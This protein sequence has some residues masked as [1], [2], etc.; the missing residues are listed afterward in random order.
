[1]NGKH[2]KIPIDNYLL[3]DLSEVDRLGDGFSICWND[4]GYSWKIASTYAKVI[5]NKLDT[6]KYL[7]YQPISNDDN[8]ISEEYKRINC[9]VFLIR[10]DRQPWGDLKVKYVFNQ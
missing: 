3:L 9:G 7:Y 2:E 5:E 1:M 6:T 8:T 4:N 10:E